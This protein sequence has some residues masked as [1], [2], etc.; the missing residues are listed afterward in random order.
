MLLNG[1]LYNSEAWHS[2]TLKDITELEK[3]DEA[4]LR[5]LLGCHSKTPLEFL[6]EELITCKQS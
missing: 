6:Q 5:Y 4:L 3:I 2:L 1:L